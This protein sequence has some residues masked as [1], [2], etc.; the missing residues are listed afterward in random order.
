MRQKTRRR[1]PG[2]IFGGIMRP[3][4]WTIRGTPP[5]S[6][7]G[8]GATCPAETIT[9][10]AKATAKLKVTG[11]IDGIRL[12]ERRSCIED[13]FQISAG[14]LRR[15]S[16][17]EDLARLERYQAI[18]IVESMLHVVR[19]VDQGYRLFLGEFGENAHHIMPGRR[20]E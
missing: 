9:R 14:H 20:I 18:G 3:T 6:C 7:S 4:R 13:V 10:A 8:E 19:G 12:S 16:V 17:E 5:A 15:R 2:S 1:K 11:E